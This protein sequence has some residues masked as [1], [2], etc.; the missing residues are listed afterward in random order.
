MSNT[1]KVIYSTLA[2]VMVVNSFVFALPIN[3]TAIAGNLDIVTTKDKSE[4]SFKTKLDKIDSA[5]PVVR[6]AIKQENSKEV[7]FE[8][9]DKNIKLNLVDGKIG[10]NKNT[11][12]QI[13]LPKTLKYEMKGDKVVGFD[14]NGDIGNTIE[15]VEGGFRIVINIKDSKAKTYTYDFPLVAKNG[16]KYTMDKDGAVMLVDSKGSRLFS[17]LSPWAVDVKDKQLKTWYTIENKGT[18]LRQNI[19]LKG[20][21]FPVI[22]DPAWC[23]NTVQNVYW[24]NWEGNGQIYSVLPTWCG[25]YGSNTSTLWNDMLAMKSINWY[26][27]SLYLGKSVSSI[28]NSVYHQLECH[29]MFGFY[30]ERYNLDI[31]R[32]DAPTYWDQYNAKCNVN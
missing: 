28:Q 9:K 18:V 10:I 6:D 15:N 31:W 16:E 1:F 13:E 20:A 3:T 8:G 7:K 5:N 4:K 24:S 29:N 12:F 32:K 30:K 2:V 27:W 17:V 19:D 22:A 25:R 26:G 11:D 23:G 14:A 21:S